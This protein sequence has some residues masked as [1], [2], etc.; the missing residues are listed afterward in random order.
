MLVKRVLRLKCGSRR[1]KTTQ[2]RRTIDVA[3]GAHIHDI[4]E[5]IDA[6][7]GAVAVAGVVNYAEEFAIVETGIRLV[8]RFAGELAC[9]AERAG[10]DTTEFVVFVV[11]F[12]NHVFV[13]VRRWS[14]HEG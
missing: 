5:T 10:R 8:A 13:R 2:K 3:A 7:V 14:E 1:E 4:A 6:K 11:I 9:Q 12:P